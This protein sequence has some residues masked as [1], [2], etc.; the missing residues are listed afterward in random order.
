MR[1]TSSFIPRPR[2]FLQSGTSL[3]FHPERHFSQSWNPLQQ[4]SVIKPCTKAWPN[5][6]SV[7]FLI[8]VLKPDYP[9][10]LRRDRES[11][12]SR[13]A[14][15]LPP[16]KGS[17]ADGAKPA[18]GVASQAEF[19][20]MGAL[21]ATVPRRQDPALSPGV[22]PLCHFESAERKFLQISKSTRWN[23]LQERGAL[24]QKRFYRI[25]SWWNTIY[26][27]WILC[28]PFHLSLFYYHW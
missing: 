20:Y 1:I 12:G 22:R 19:L 28:F 14:A 25:I 2:R 27:H 3:A 16:F 6:N 21:D 23:L 9:F 5:C 24:G 10:Q 26:L 15:L 8:R 13:G 7:W 18:D 17:L 4:T 11:F